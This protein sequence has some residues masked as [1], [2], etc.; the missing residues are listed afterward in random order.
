[1]A[2]AELARKAVDQVQARRHH[3]VDSG[4]HHNLNVILVKQPYFEQEHRQKIQRDD[5]RRGIG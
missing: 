5:D 2:D 1:M 4:K 3:N